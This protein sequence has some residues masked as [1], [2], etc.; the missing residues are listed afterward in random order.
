MASD[1][2]GSA[3]EQQLSWATIVKVLAAILVAYM[4]VR[5]WPLIELLMVAMLIAITLAPLLRWTR[6][7]GWPKWLGVSLCALILFGSALLLFGFVL[8]TIFTQGGEFI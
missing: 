7:H 6:D 2:S 1:A 5:L 4:L 8:P 3:R